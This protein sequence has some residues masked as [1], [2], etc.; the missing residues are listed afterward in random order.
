MS[1]ESI[2]N[3][4]AN[5]SSFFNWLNKWLCKK[6]YKAIDWL[7]EKVQLYSRWYDASFTF[8]HRCISER[9]AICN[10]SSGTSHL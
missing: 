5:A 2:S 7:A 10:L 3:A 8:K 6:M 9:Q 1:F 4:V